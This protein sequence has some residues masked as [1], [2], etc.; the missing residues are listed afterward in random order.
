MKTSRSREA[1]FTPQ[2]IP[3]HNPRRIF[4]LPIRPLHGNPA[5]HQ[6]E[7]SQNFPSQV[8]FRSL[9]AHPPYQ[10]RPFAKITP[11][12][13]RDEDTPRTIPSARSPQF[14]KRVLISLG[15]ISHMLRVM[16]FPQAG[17]QTQN[18]I[19]TSTPEASMRKR[20]WRMVGKSREARIMRSEVLLGTRAW[21][22]DT[23]HL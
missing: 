4:P 9:S 2:R 20:C 15:H 3:H 7:P 10:R 8:P 12:P 1:V 14:P 21:E 11:R 23:D 13:A 19:L 17:D 5:P 22:R 18:S 16:R 6:P